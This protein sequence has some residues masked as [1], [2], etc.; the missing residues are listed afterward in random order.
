[1]KHKKITRMHGEAH[2]D[3]RPSDAAKLGLIFALSGPK[4][5]YSAEVRMLK[6][7]LEFVEPFSG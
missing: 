1:M 2:R 6:E 3:G 7:L 4:Y 5:T